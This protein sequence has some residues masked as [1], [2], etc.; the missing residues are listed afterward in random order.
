MKSGTVAEVQFYSSGMPR[1]SEPNG[2]MTAC[3]TH[4]RKHIASA[5]HHHTIATRTRRQARP[6]GCHKPYLRV[7]PLDDVQADA[8][9]SHA[10]LGQR[11]SGGLNVRTRRVDVGAVSQSLSQTPRHGTRVDNHN[12]SPIDDGCTR[13]VCGVPDEAIQGTLQKRVSTCQYRRLPRAS[14][15]T[16][17]TYIGD[18]EWM[19]HGTS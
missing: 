4:I 14:E 12:T 11:D 2:D 16:S 17:F 13:H 1:S 9:T 10:L 15:L 8:T 5:V 19:S 7:V 3:A 6:D 18:K